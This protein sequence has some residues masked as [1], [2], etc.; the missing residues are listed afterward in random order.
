M[1]T[2]LAMIA[3]EM[4]ELAGAALAAVFLLQYVRERFGGVTLR[5]R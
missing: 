5:V 4:C 3:E 1:H 2:G